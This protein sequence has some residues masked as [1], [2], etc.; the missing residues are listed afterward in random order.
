MKL[1]GRKVET[2]FGAADDVGEPSARE[3]P[4]WPAAADGRER[5]ASVTREITGAGG[6]GGASCAGGWLPVPPRAAEAR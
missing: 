1:T 3:L 5:S 4:S 6:A 2:V